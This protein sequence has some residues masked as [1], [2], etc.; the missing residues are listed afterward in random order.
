[1][2]SWYVEFLL[3]NQNNI[4]SSIMGSN[5]VGLSPL[6]GITE[7]ELEFEEDIFYKFGA[8]EFNFEDETYQDLLMIE[9]T[10]EELR[11]AH[12]ISSAEYDIVELI[13]NNT[14]IRDIISKLDLDKRTVY[15]VFSSVCERIAYIL[16]GYY[17]NEGFLDK[18]CKN[19]K[20][21]EEQIQKIRNYFNKNTVEKF[22]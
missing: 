13:K 14:N 10:I 22:L 17:T 7:I 1:M 20:L 18:I 5:I 3:K 2:G 21:T 6:I 15:G 9:K 8:V 11:Q 16:G 19:R 12:K 4:R